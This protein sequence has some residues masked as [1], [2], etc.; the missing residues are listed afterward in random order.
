MIKFLDLCLIFNSAHNYQ[1]FLWLYFISF[2]KYVSLIKIINNDSTQAHTL[3][4]KTTSLLC[5]FMCIYAALLLQNHS[6]LLCNAESSWCL[7]CR[8]SNGWYLVTGVDFFLCWSAATWC[9]SC[10][11]P[12]QVQSVCILVFS[13]FLREISVKLLIQSRTIISDMG[14][15]YFLHSTFISTRKSYSCQRE[16]KQAGNGG[17]YILIKN[18]CIEFPSFN[19]FYL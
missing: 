11:F 10:T 5:L 9:P 15:I 18:K 2:L 1:S 14:R 8:P 13:L 19:Q 4:K 3:S 17:N 6:Y 16:F 12:S 7:T